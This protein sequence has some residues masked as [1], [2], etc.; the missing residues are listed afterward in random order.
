MSRLVRGRAQEARSQ[1]KAARTTTETRRVT[2]ALRHDRTNPAEA[3]T[4]RA[5]TFDSLRDSTHTR[6]AGCAACIGPAG[7][8]KGEGERG[9]W[10]LRSC[11]G[12]AAR[13]AGTA[14]GRVCVRAQPHFPF[15]Q[16]L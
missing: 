16:G 1:A 7:R 10:P 4:A 12:D 13:A 3:S 6:L 9:G 15:L 5:H 11:P 2:G 8:G 14:P